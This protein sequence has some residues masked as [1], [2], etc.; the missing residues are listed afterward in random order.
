MLEISEYTY[1]HVMYQILRNMP[2]KS[3]RDKTSNLNMSVIKE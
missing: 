1:I 3:Y 2:I